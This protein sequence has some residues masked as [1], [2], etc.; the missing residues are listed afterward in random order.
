MM[1]SSQHIAGNRP[2]TPTV[3][4]LPRIFFRFFYLGLIGF[5][6]G[7]AV[8]GLMQ[9]EC[10]EKNPCISSEDF[11]RGVTFSQ[12]LGS[13]AVNTAF[14]IGY[15]M[16]GISGALAAVVGF[17]SPS[18][19]MVVILSFFY[20]HFHRLPQLRSALVGIGPVVIA[21]IVW[22]A[23]QIGRPSIK[24]K[25]SIVI[26]LFAFWASI[27]HFNTLAILLIAG[28]LG[29]LRFYLRKATSQ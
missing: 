20:F 22:A 27:A 5:G 28:G 19:W 21:L 14:F 2:P 4:S 24:S 6:G 26:A 29:I 16:A 1:R 8:I 15:E 23:Y 7:Q 17:L 3:L 18:F 13:F 25:T 12:V 11:L 10:V 9:R